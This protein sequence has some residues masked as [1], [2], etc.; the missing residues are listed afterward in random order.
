M[1]IEH[2]FFIHAYIFML[3]IYVS[4]KLYYVTKT[5]FFPLTISHAN[6]FR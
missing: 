5:S 6:G 1:H 4:I 2:I 3:H